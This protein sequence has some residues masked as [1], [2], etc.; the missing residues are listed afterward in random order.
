MRTVVSVCIK[1]A[2]ET[3]IRSVSELYSGRVC[4]AIEVSEYDS[5]VRVYFSEKHYD[6]YPF[7]NVVRTSYITS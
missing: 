4:T 3:V 1:V 6:E 2:K 5:Y 7:A